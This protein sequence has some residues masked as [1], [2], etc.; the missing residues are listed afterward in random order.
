MN[1]QIKE[2]L[3][4]VINTAIA[5]EQ[6]AGM[7]L[8]I[9][10]NNREQLY[11]NCGY[12]DR[13]ARKEI[14]RDTIFRLFS[15]T[16]PVTSAAV[17]IL[18]QR[19]LIDLTDPVSKYI[20]S[21]KD[22]MV[23]V[24]GGFEPARSPVTIQNLLS[25]TGGLTYDGTAAAPESATQK[26][27]DE[28]HARMYGDTPVDTLEFAEKIGRCPL[29]YHPGTS[30]K[31]SVSADILAAVVEKVSGMSFGEFLHR[32][33]FE[34]LGM[35]DTGFFVPEAKQ[36]RLA[37]PYQCTED[38]LKEF[39]R[40]YLGI[41]M[42]MSAPPAYEAGGAGLVSTIDDYAKFASMLLNKGTFLGKQILLPAA[43]DYMTTHR[44]TPEQQ[45]GF[46][47]ELPGMHGFSYGNLLRVMT[48]PWKTSFASVSG[49]YGWDGWLGCYF[50]NI[51]SKDMTILMMM[52]RT[53]T[54]TF[55]LTRRLRNI[56]LLNL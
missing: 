6:L 17:M 20:S 38:G 48:D 34:P 26:V 54:G 40:D 21:F 1:A 24:S 19:G 23:S 30:W 9:Q 39:H 41:C 46:D 43:V 52:Q 33:I 18:F 28:V 35:N 44:L 12:A 55:E 45:K 27:F 53:D 10:Q 29:K 56:I 7:S 49:E 3:T 2:Q 36:H 51:P 37:V 4:N 50:A 11:L 13:T 16:K 31:Y 47:Q 32:E 8:L 14:Q 15:M 42:S 22:Q 5:G 25:M